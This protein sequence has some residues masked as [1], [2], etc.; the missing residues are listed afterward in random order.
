MQINSVTYLLTYFNMICIKFDQKIKKTHKN[1]NFGLLRFLKPKNLGFFSKPF[2]ALLTARAAANE[3][4]S[5]R[6]LV[7][8]PSTRVLVNTGRTLIQAASLPMTNKGWWV[9]VPGSEGSD[10]GP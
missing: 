9:S 2:P 5:T 1:I 8:V 6:V 10:S 3:L 4:F 7:R